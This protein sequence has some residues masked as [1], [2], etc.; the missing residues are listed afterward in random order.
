MKNVYLLFLPLIF[1][2][3]SCKNRVDYSATNDNSVAMPATLWDD[4]DF[5]MYY[6]PIDTADCVL[7]W[8]AFRNAVINR[9]T[10]ALNFM[11]CDT[12]KA[13]CWIKGFGG[14]MMSKS[15]FVQKIYSVFT[16]SHLRLL[17]ESDL[18]KNL[19]V[20]KK[21]WQ[22]HYLFWTTID[23]TEYSAS[24]YFENNIFIYSMSFSTGENS[25]R[26][27]YLRFKQTS[28]GVKLFDLYDS[29]WTID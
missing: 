12:I 1:T 17:I 16:P 25:G 13:A 5:S 23:D 26:G 29:I 22:E 7:Y 6:L 14:V 4:D 21:K 27:R 19:D 9:D 3:F 2:V 24:L 28:D 15:D 10:I 8:Q 20:K 18:N 11:I